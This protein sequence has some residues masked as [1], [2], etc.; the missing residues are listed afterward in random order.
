MI[1]DG[2]H[3]D[4]DCFIESSVNEETGKVSY[5]IITKLTAIPEQQETINGLDQQAL[6][7]MQ[8]K[9]STYNQTGSLII[10]FLLTIDKQSH[11]QCLENRLSMLFQKNQ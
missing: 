10:P 2:T 1:I 4:P 3:V 7:A 5:K 9:L 6:L 11:L 8:K